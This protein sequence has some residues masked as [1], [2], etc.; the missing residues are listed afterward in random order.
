MPN[1]VRYMDLDELRLMTDRLCE[2]AIWTRNG[3]YLRDARELVSKL[4]GERSELD[5]I[6]AGARS[7]VGRPDAPR[8]EREAI[9]GQICDAILAHTACTCREQTV[10]Y[11]IDVIKSR[12]ALADV[13]L[14][15]SYD[16]VP[17]EVMDEYAA[18]LV[19]QADDAIRGLALI[20]P[21]T[22]RDMAFDYLHDHPDRA[23]DVRAYRRVVASD[24]FLDFNDN[25]G[26]WTEHVIQ[27]HPWRQDLERR[28]LPLRE[29][30]MELDGRFPARDVGAEWE[31][32]CACA[33]DRVTS[34]AL[35]ERGTCAE[36]LIIAPS[37]ASRLRD[38][39]F[40]WE[41]TPDAVRLV[42]PDERTLLEVSP[43]SGEVPDLT[44]MEV[45][46]AAHSLLVRGDG[47]GALGNDA[48][49]LADEVD[50]RAC[51]SPRVADVRPRVI[52]GA[53]RATTLAGD[54]R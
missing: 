6:V 26:S 15:V 11:R 44:P 5:E 7:E 45:A 50:A 41:C 34:V 17:P 9:E 1:R 10:G 42:S 49:R 30:L 8:D 2:Y 43:R 33:C 21:N 38:R 28:L 22:A 40:C 25:Y 35:D 14:D 16:G 46:D 54:Q 24:A 36:P 23:A 52:E 53:R 13:V 37:R 20:A 31:L 27:A 51:A 47:F 3:C 19:D 18:V 12:L 48:A 39:V 32:M 4:C 29:R